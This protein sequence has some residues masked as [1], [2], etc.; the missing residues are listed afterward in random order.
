MKKLVNENKIS[1]DTTINFTE[2]WYF[3]KEMLF[4]ADAVFT[5]Q[6]SNGKPILTVMSVVTTNLL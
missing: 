2:K 6:V 3:G 4:E 5:G 1:I